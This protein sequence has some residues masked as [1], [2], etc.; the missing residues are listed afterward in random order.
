MGRP[1]ASNTI[2]DF[3]A[4]FA[5]TVTVTSTCQYDWIAR[6]G[7][8]GVF[9]LLS[10]LAPKVRFDAGRMY[11][12]SGNGSLLHVLSRHAALTMK[13]TS[14]GSIAIAYSKPYDV[15]TYGIE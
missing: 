3:A 12:L 10:K 2:R 8:H 15:L 1:R 9:T 6:T 5:N 11:T 14:T 4:T 13:K 7:K